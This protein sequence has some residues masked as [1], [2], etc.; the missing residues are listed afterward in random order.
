MLTILA[1]EK[2]RNT[3]KNRRIAFIVCV[4]FVVFTLVSLCYIEKEANHHC[5]GEDCPICA[6]IQQAEN[7]IKTT[8]ASSAVAAGN[9]V[10]N[11]LYVFTAYVSVIIIL[12]ASLV[13]KKVRMDNWIKP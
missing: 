8:W 4:I 3:N 7:I 6:C 10:V 1:G 11:P 2:K 12:G 13:S 5:T 9:G